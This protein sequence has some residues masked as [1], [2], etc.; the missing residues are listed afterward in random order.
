MKCIYTGAHIRTDDGIRAGDI[1][2]DLQTGEVE[3]RGLTPVLPE[4]QIH[5]CTLVDGVAETTESGIRIANASLTWTAL[6]RGKLLVWETVYPKDF[7][8]ED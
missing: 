6:A 2:Y 8:A 1:F 7:P 4:A 3:I 5:E